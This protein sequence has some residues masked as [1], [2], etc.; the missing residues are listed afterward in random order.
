[1]LKGWDNWRAS[2][3]RWM[4]AI[5]IRVPSLFSTLAGVAVRVSGAVASLSSK[6]QKWS[7]QMT[8]AITALILSDVAEQERKVNASSE[9]PEIGEATG[10]AP[11]AQRSILQA[12]KERMHG[13]GVR[14]REI[15]GT[16]KNIDG[17]RQA[18]GALR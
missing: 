13:H 9:A 3:T 7:C 4:C 12:S 5:A 8:I 15:G 18:G 17:S 10:G 16:Y 14:R 1:M 6:R 2:S 11:T